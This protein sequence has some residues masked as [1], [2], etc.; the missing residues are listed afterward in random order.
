MKAASRFDV[1]VSGQ[2]DSVAFTKLG[3]KMRT[4]A[5]ELGYTILFDYRNAKVDISI[6]EV[7]FW[8]RDHLDKVSIRFRSIPTAHLTNENNEQ[9]FRF[10][11]LTWTNA[12]AVV[13][14]FKECSDAEK[15]LV[16]FN[17][18]NIT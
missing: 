18:P 17:G 3:I 16:N 11:D 9:L 12:G 1:V 14:T 6:G 2:V 10:A 13:K 7:Y 15:W 8:F 5:L 4:L